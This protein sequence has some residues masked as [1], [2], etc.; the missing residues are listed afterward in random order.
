MSVS[1]NRRIRL[2]DERQLLSILENQ[3]RLIFES[4]GDE[5][6]R[7][8]LLPQGFARFNDMDPAWVSKWLSE[9]HS[10]DGNPW[11]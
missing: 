3:L 1:D 6:G 5:P 7:N 10:N 11:D 8:H 2:F 9:P 4:R